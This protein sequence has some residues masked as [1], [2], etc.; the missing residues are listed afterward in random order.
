MHIEYV[1]CI[2]HT[3]TSK[4]NNKDEAKAAHLNCL[5]LKIYFTHMRWVGTWEYVCVFS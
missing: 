3:H 1:I 2:Q 4:Y 5:A